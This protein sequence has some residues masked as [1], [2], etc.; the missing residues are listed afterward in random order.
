MPRPPAPSLGD[1]VY[2]LPDAARL[3]GIPLPKLRSWVSGYVAVKSERHYPMGGIASYGEGRG[4]IF[5]FLTLIEVFVVARLR[6]KGV[7]MITIR[8]GRKE[9]AQRFKTSHPFALKGLLTDGKKLLKELGDEALLEL[10]TGGQTG[11][12]AVLKPFCE[13]LEFEQF[14]GLAARFYPN[15]CEGKIV[16]D[17]HLSFG[18]PVIAGSSTTTAA[19]AALVRGGEK[20]EDIASDF[21]LPITSLQEAWEFEERLKAA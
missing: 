14:T 20:L 3:L 15:G 7:S 17:P 19:I 11:F 16:V 13:H 8:K 4:K 12:E 21:D 2:T 6:E 18:R 9:L 10:G 5:S 1:G